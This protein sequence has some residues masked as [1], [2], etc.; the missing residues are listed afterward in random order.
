MIDISF[1]YINFFE[2]NFEHHYYTNNIAKTIEIFPTRET[3]LFLE[4]FNII[5][6]KTEVAYGLFTDTFNCIPFTETLRLTEDIRLNFLIKILDK[7]FFQTST[8]KQKQRNQFLFFQNKGDKLTS[9]AFI[10]DKNYEYLSSNK[11]QAYS[12]LLQSKGFDILALIEINLTK[13]ERKQIADCLAQADSEKKL[14]YKAAFDAPK[15]YWRYILKA[16]RTDEKYHLEIKS[17]KNKVKFLPQAS[18]ASDSDVF[19]FQSE[20]AIE[21]K[22]KNKLKLELWNY[23][24]KTDKKKGKIINP[25]LPVPRTISYYSGTTKIPISEIYIHI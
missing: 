23:K 12:G 14:R 18:P 16:K 3:Q 11:L 8:I 7:T 6:K 19:I 2:L 10:S 4:R 24:N 13:K 25:Y 15:S 22:E 21:I 5:L 9:E 20:K 17:L 1:K